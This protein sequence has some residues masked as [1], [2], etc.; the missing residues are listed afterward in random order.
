MSRAFVPIVALLL[1]TGSA[2][3]QTSS[4]ASRPLT[5][6]AQQDR[7]KTCNTAAGERNFAGEARKNFMSACL[8]G[9]QTPQVMMK[10][11]NMEASQEK[12]APDAR[13]AYLGT[14]LKS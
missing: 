1:A 10:I 11:C 5:Q 9:K 6:L 4:P 14:C 12:M 13:K 8:A 7:M 2:F 3:A